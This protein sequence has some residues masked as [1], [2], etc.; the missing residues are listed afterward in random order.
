MSAARF[1]LRSLTVAA[2]LTLAA[3][4]PAC[5]DDDPR[6]PDVFWDYDHR[7]RFPDASTP[8]APA[9]DVPAPDAAPDVPADV[10]A[11]VIADDATEAP[12]APDAAP[13]DA[14]LPDAADAAETD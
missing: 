14:A 13:P 9:V 2:A 4:A 3:L 7:G 1:S 8:D 10:P 5:R 11:D 12:D 6:P